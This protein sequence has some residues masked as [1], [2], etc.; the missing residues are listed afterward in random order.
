MRGPPLLTDPDFLSGSLESNFS[1]PRGA[2]SLHL[3][4]RQGGAGGGNLESLAWPWQGV[5]SALLL[6]P[7]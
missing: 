1:L 6:R 7:L 5:G 3:R 4:P 2:E